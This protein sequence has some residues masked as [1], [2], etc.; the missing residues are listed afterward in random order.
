MRPCWGHLS[1]TVSLVGELEIFLPVHY[2]YLLPF[3][4]SGRQ[5]MSLIFCFLIPPNATKLEE[6]H[7]TRVNKRLLRL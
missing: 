1:T 2:D 3:V 6:I 5:L 7:E 4:T